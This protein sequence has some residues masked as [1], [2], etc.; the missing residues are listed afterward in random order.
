MSR[1]TG[2]GF[3]NPKPYRGRLEAPPPPDDNVEE[4]IEVSSMID[5]EAV[6]RFREAD[7]KIDAA[8]GS[9]LGKVF[10]MVCGIMAILIV[11]SI[12][13]AILAAIWESIVS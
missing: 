7:E 13:V 4:T 2:K 12:G 5:E 3:Y 8:M 6:R 11:I 1:F 9:L 10:K